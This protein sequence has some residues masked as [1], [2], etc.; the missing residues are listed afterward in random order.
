MHQGAARLVHLAALL[1]FHLKGLS[2]RDNDHGRG[3]QR[4]PRQRASLVQV[5][6]RDRPRLAQ[7]QMIG[8]MTIFQRAERL[9]ADRLARHQP[10][11]HAVLAAQEVRVGQRHA[12]RCEPRL[13][14]A[15]RHAQTEIRHIRRK[16]RQRMIRIAPTPK[17]FGG[18]RESQR[19]CRQLVAGFEIRLHAVENLGLVDF[20]GEGGHRLSRSIQ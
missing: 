17:P 15:G 14:T 13:A 12:L 8:V 10:Q 9:L 11:D 18:G 3:I 1:V 4:R 2:C 19:R 5:Q 20:G 6:H 7:G 16:T